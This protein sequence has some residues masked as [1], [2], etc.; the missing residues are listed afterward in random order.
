MKIIC[1]C[2]CGCTIELIDSIQKGIC[3]PC[4]LG[5]PLNSRNQHRPEIL[6]AR[7]KEES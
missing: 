3:K 7:I 2:P 5:R 1:E 4:R 6:N